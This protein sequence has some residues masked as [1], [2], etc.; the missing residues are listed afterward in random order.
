MNSSL[1]ELT[2][3]VTVEVKKVA[4]WR[5]F[6]FAVILNISLPF[7]FLLF[8]RLTSVFPQVLYIIFMSFTLSFCLAYTYLLYR[9]RCP[10]CLQKWAFVCSSKKDVYTKLTE[11]KCCMCKHRELYRFS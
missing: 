9:H 5:S 11:Y 2:A 7:L 1:A 3:N 10:C 8:F 4:F 6:Y